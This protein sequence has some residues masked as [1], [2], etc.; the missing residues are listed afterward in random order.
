MALGG[1]RAGAGRK[2]GSL[3]GH[4]LKTQEQRIKA[5]QMVDDNLEKIFQPQIE[6]AIKGDTS[7]F[8]AVLDRAWGKPLQGLELAGKGGK[9]LFVPPTEKIIELAKLL[10][11]NKRH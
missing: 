4:T 11:E 7:A 2:K 8:S 9:D 3:A 1:K 5:I 10:N 6:K